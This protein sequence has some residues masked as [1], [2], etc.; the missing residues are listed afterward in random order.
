[1]T[2]RTKDLTWRI[3]G[4]L[5]LAEELAEVLGAR[6][7]W[8][9]KRLAPPGGVP[10]CHIKTR[11]NVTHWE[12]DLAVLDH[13]EDIKRIADRRLVCLEVHTEAGA[14][15]WCS[16]Y[17][18]RWL[19]G[20]AWMQPMGGAPTFD[21]V[22]PLL[23]ELSE[24]LNESWRRDH[25]APPAP[26]DRLTP[27]GLAPRDAKLRWWQHVAATVN[28]YPLTPRESIDDRSILLSI[29][30]A[31]EDDG[32]GAEQCHDHWLTR[33]Q[34]EQLRDRLCSMLEHLD[35]GRTQSS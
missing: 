18:D 10:N 19:R 35:T 2:N 22:R 20:R 26:P 15:V 5:G 27:T 29:I 33:E 32:E 6:P 16:D 28:V 9:S 1:M 21:E 31:D 12:G 14:P 3:K 25:L 34:A 23:E 4:K 7:T 11:D 13:A 24:E 17:P 30:W 8:S